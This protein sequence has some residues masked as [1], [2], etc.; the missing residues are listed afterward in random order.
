[1]NVDPH[2][3]ALCVQRN[4]KRRYCNFLERVINTIAADDAERDQVRKQ[5]KI[6]KEEI[7]VL[8]AEIEWY[9]EDETRICIADNDYY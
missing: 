4:N 3:S 5:V 8:S 6:Y 7:E 2:Y 9:E 1:M